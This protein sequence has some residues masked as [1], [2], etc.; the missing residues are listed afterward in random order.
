M[1]LSGS[2]LQGAKTEWA[3]TKRHESEKTFGIQVCGSKP[4]QLAPCAEAIVKQCPDVD[5]VDVNL[6][7]VHL[8]L[9]GGVI[10]SPCADPDEP[11]FFQM[12]DRS[13]LQQGS[14]SVESTLSSHRPLGV[15]ALTTCSLALRFSGS[16][17]FDH[18]SE[19]SLVILFL[20]PSIMWR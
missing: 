17:L 14:W 1:G 8:C 12:P 20:S 18:P 3:L 19:P 4:I 16:A 7:S 15:L 2:F 13:R 10:F 9:I 11:F 5:F 6:G